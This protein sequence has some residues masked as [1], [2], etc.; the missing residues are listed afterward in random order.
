MSSNI[1]WKGRILRREEVLALVGVSKSTLDNWTTPESGYYDPSFPEPV[2]VGARRVGWYEEE[3]KAWVASRSRFRTRRV[4]R[5]DAPS[6]SIAGSSERQA[7]VRGSPE[8]RSAI[9]RDVQ[10]LLKRVAHE[11]RCVTKEKF[12]QELRNLVGDEGLQVSDDELDAI[13][14]ASYRRSKLLPTVVLHED[15]APSGRLKRVA[16]MLGVQLSV[17]QVQLQRERLFLAHQRPKDRKPVAFRWNQ[18]GSL[19]SMNPLY[20]GEAAGPLRLEREIFLSRHGI[21][22]E[23][24]R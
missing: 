8:Q 18:A 3:V 20:E 16:S 14:Q 19:L 11:G 5:R 10:S 12:L 15:G 6:P 22:S 7:S 24:N 13:D 23:E 9:R 17:Q 21:R 4:S 1:A 2:P